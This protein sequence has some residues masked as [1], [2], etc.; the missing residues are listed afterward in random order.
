[1]ELFDLMVAQVVEL[2]RLKPYYLHS[3]VPM[4]MVMVIVVFLVILLFHQYMIELCEETLLDQLEVIHEVIR[5]VLYA[6]QMND[7]EL[8]VE[9]N[10]ALV[11]VLM[12]DLVVLA[13]DDVLVL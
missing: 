10:V 5:V 2:M 4:K 11:L 1:V 6:L 12:V 8:K 3:I 13:N 9:E 7:V